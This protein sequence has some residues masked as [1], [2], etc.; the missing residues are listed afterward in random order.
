MMS[1]ILRHVTLYSLA[2]M[3]PV[4]GRC[5]TS[6][7]RT[8][9]YSYC[10]LGLFFDS[11]DRSS[12][13]L[14]N[15]DKFPLDYTASYPRDG[16]L[17]V[18]TYPHLLLPWDL[19]PTQGTL[20]ITW[21]GIYF[22]NPLEGPHYSEIWSNIW[23]TTLGRNFYFTTG[24]AACE[25]RSAT[26]NLGTKSA[27]AL[28]PRKT[29]ENLDRVGRSQDLPDANWLLASS[30]AL[31]TR[32]LTLVPV[33]LLLYLKEVYMFVFTDLSFYV[34]TLDEHRTVVYNICEENTCLYAHTCIDIC[35]YLNIGE[36]EHLLWWGRG[37]DVVWC[38][39]LSQ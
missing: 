39:L 32:I 11:E 36:F 8:E 22:L 16:A 23:R 18:K 13:F 26:W 5:T 19:C 37:S 7:L 3:Y 9:Q 24:R 31:N 10:L 4:S 28:G 38:L 30:P 21:R 12:T 33:W 2:E 27:S 35:D 29:T 1:T 15:I 6:I 14:R 17:P 34:R 25:A 20:L